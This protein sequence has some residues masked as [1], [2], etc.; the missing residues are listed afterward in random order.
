MRHLHLVRDPGDHLAM[1]V[2]GEQVAVGDE[3][4]VA[5]IGEAAESTLPEGATPVRM[6]RLEYDQL[7]ELLDWCDRVVSW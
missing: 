6:A 7:V 4:R 1:D 2:V 3:V 5:L